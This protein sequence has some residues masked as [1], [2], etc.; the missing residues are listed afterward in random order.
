MGQGKRI[1][2]AVAFIAVLGGCAAKGPGAAIPQAERPAGKSQLVLYKMGMPVVWGETTVLVDDREVCTLA[3]NEF[4]ALEVPPGLHKVSTRTSM[5][6]VTSVMT[7]MMRS[8]A[9]SYVSFRTNPLRMTLSTLLGPVSALWPADEESAPG[10]R[11]FLEQ[12]T[13]ETAEIDIVRMTRK[14]CFRPSR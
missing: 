9:T 8:G 2:L 11:L 12:V 4:M 1:W 6:L 3:V 14:T 5:T 7:V 10:S 13:R